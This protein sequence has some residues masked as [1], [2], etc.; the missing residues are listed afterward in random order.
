MLGRVLNSVRDAGDLL[1]EVERAAPRE[2][3]LVGVEDAGHLGQAQHLERG[4]V[5]DVGR[6]QGIDARVVLA[7][8]WLRHSARPV[9]ATVRRASRSAPFSNAALS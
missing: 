1:A 6:L 8:I 2:L 9:P 5:D 4:A 7:W 3:G